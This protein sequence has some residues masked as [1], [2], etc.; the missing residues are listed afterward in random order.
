MTRVRILKS[1]KDIA[2]ADWNGCATST[3]VPYNPFVSYEFLSALEV[4]GSAT[5]ETGWA[6]NHFVKDDE[7]KIVGAMPC[8]LK[9][10]SQGEY[11]FDY[12][13]AEAFQRAG[14][15]YY[16][17]LQISVPFS[18]C[19]GPRALAAT[20][21][22]KQ[23]LA[24]A[25]ISYCSSRNA[26][27]AHITFA[28][29]QDIQALSNDKWILRQDIQFHWRNDGYNSFEDFL[30]SLSSSK[31]KNVKKER[32]SVAENGITFE[33]LTGKDLTENHWDHFFAF[34]MDTGSRKWGRP[35][36]TRTFFSLI[37]ET[38]AKNTLLVMAKRDGRY[39]AGALNF[40][41]GDTLYGRNWGC[42]ENHPCLHFEACY[43][44]AQDFAIAHSLK[45]VE[46]GAQGEHK[47]ARGY[48]PVKTQ[49]MHY[50]AHPGL[51]RAVSD[52]LANERAAVSHDQ[53]LLVEHSPF[54]QSHGDEE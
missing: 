12:G 51:R 53:S 20:H 18:P 30:A 10:H 24:E 37:T 14:G 7:G 22:I 25:A 26:S 17:K 41:G 2:A 8:Y 4:S 34:Y 52:Y 50:L 54:R 32:R 46:A 15:R 5:H 42:L 48:L 39:I 21:E 40:I 28:S 27:S 49:S 36:L 13:W 16:P 11:V 23:H 35:Y 45:T 43:Y 31:R 3:S 44:Q 19:T 6:P 33:H 9:S 38:M 29:E 1:L 47:L